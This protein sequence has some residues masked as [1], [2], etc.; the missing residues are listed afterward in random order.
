MDEPEE[1]RMN[2][3]WCRFYVVESE[4]QHFEY[5]GPWWVSGWALSDPPAAVVCAAVLAASEDAP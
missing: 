3:Y 5:H 1:V 4:L 2:R